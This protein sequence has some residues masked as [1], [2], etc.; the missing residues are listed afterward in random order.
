MPTT[1]N[2][3]GSWFGIASCAIAVVVVVIL[4]QTTDINFQGVYSDASKSVGG[5]L[6]NNLESGIWPLC[7]AIVAGIA[8]AVASLRGPSDRR[9]IAWV[10]L[11]INTLLLLL[12]ALFLA[13]AYSQGAFR[14]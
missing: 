1:S 7:G 12:V 6:T 13:L 3:R 10:G 4:V 8:L 5:G 2:R 11:T 14:T 9:W